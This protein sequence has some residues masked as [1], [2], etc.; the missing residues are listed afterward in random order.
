ME[1]LIG[2]SVGILFLA[3]KVLLASASM[4]PRAMGVG[5]LEGGLQH[6]DVNI[7][8][9]GRATEMG[10]A[11]KMKHG[12]NE[13]GCSSAMESVPMDLL[14]PCCCQAWVHA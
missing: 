3:C 1:P 12:Q 6:G 8:V 11:G 10:M 14:Q 13:T 7:D 5:T 4:E 2:F 9:R